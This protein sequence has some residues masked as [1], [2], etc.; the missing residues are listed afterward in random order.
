MIKYSYPEALK[1]NNVFKFWRA[2][3]NFLL[4]W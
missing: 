3:D 4:F 1:H 2:I